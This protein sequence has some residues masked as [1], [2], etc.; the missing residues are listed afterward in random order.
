MDLIKIQ[1]LFYLSRQGDSGKITT[2]GIFLRVLI[3]AGILLGAGQF[4]VVPAFFSQPCKLKQSEVRTYVGS[5]NKGQ[6]AY[7]IERKRF[8]SNIEALGVGI[9]TDT[10]NFTYATKSSPYDGEN[11][12]NNYAL[13]FSIN[14]PREDRNLTNFWKSEAR[15]ARNYI[16]RV[17]LAY[18]L[19]TSEVT[20]LAILCE[21][22]NVDTPVTIAHTKFTQLP[23]QDATLECVGDAEALEN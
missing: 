9:T 19:E 4:L 14:A 20:S 10:K 17:N 16:G 15:P 23:G 8:G 6:Q 2:K 5:L 3:Y 7:F 22:K 18:V 12:T 13:S 1:L 21:H 11:M